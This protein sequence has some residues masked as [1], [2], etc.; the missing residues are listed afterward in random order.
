MTPELWQRLKPLFHA[1]LEESAEGRAAFVVA[2]CGDDEE[3]KMH[4]ERLIAA[5]QQGSRKIDA[6]LVD[7]HEL[8]DA[9]HAGFQYRGGSVLLAEKTR[10]GPYEIIDLLG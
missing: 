9:R 5:E 1:A 6:P 4:L 2:A 3:L 10:L 8:N 7:L